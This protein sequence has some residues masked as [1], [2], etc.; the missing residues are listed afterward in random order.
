MTQGHSRQQRS[1]PPRQRCIFCREGGVSGNP[2]TEEH[3]WSEWMH[4]YLPRVPGMKTTSSRRTVRLGMTDV[5]SKIRVGAVFTKRFRLVCKKCN[6]GWMSGLETAAKPI[7]IPMLQGQRRTVLKKDRVTLAQWLALKVMVTE[8]INRTDAVISEFERADFRL[9]RKMPRRLQIF[10]GT[11]DTQLWYMA[12][13]HQTLLAHL[14]AIPPPKAAEVLDKFKNIQTTAIGLGHIFSVSYITTIDDLK[15][16]PIHGLHRR[17]R[18]LWPNRDQP[19]VWPLPNLSLN[20]AN[21]LANCI[22]ELATAPV[23][24]W[25]PYPA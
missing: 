10:I 6:T 8:C 7:L 25:L 17:I 12:Y 16:K 5:E 22:R 2:M 18:Q 23:T 20:E 24:E 19:I 14:G 9:S 21:R 13:W 11:H 15:W 4:E 3:L 1:Q